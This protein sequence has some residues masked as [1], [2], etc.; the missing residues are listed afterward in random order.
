[1]NK[2]F[3]CA[4]AAAATG[5]LAFGSAIPADAS[6]LYLYAGGTRQSGQPSHT[7][8][9]EWQ[10]FLGANHVPP[11]Y[12]VQY[13]RDLAPLI[14]DKTLDDSVAYGVDGAQ[15]LITTHDDGD[16]IYLV[17]VSQGAVVMAKTKQARSL[18]ALTRGRSL[19]SPLVIPP[20]P[21]AASCPSWTGG[22]STSRVTRR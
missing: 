8:E 22:T 15:G 9:T 11:A 18:T 3:A 13:P 1:M 21:T 19:S 20:T 17:G 2:T 14:G 7:S 16:G 10:A 5:V 4:I 6:P 12:T